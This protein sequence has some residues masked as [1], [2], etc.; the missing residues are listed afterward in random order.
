MIV[1]APAPVGAQKGDKDMTQ[2]DR[3][4]LTIYTPGETVANAPKWALAKDDPNALGCFWIEGHPS[5]CMPLSSIDAVE[6][7]RE[8]AIYATEADKPLS[9]D[10]EDSLVTYLQDE[11]D[12]RIY[13]KFY[14]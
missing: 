2:Y 11:D 10:E 5:Y 1:T 13:E 7:A 4:G 14:K 8:C 6:V 12:T 9:E 3:L